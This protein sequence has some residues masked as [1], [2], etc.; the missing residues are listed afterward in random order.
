MKCIEIFIQKYDN[1]DESPLFAIKPNKS[2]KNIFMSYQV[3]NK[4]LQSFHS[5]HSNIPLSTRIIRKSIITNALS[6]LE[7][8]SEVTS[9]LSHDPYTAQKYYDKSKKSSE[10]NK[11]IQKVQKRMLQTN[12]S[13]FITK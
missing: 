8:L 3:V 4:I 5:A 2:S 13:K 12:R 1:N 9:A 7:D 11:Y 10:I 6:N